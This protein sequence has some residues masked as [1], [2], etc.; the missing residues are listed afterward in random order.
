MFIYSNLKVFF[1][2]ISYEP[3]NEFIESNC[4]ESNT[5]D[6]YAHHIKIVKIIVLYATTGLI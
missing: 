6:M 5:C 3:M 4:Y 1:S 2:I